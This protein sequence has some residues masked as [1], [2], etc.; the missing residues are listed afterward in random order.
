MP[1]RAKEPESAL[2]H[3]GDPGQ[4]EAY[5]YA[6]FRRIARRYDLLNRLLSGGRDVAWRRFA[7]ERTELTRGQKALD[8]A[9]GTGDLAFALARRVGPD[10]EVIGVDFVEEMLQLARTKQAGRP[11]GAVC[12]FMQGNALALPFEDGAFD[13]ATIGF[14]LRNVSDVEKCLTEMQRVVRPGGR[15]VCLELS[16]P[17]WPLF[18]N[19]Y[20]FY[21]HRLVPWIGRLIQG[22]DGPYRYLPDSVAR[23]PDQERLAEIMRSAGFEDVRYYNLTGGIAAV[24]V[25]V[26]P[27]PARAGDE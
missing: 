11:E 21:F 3:S 10:G 1:V 8:V 22:V 13:A 12:S 5:V 6:M 19:V 20:H 18:R 16:K 9:T 4:K 17:V 7:A 15:V 2:I 24:H 14:A 23:F 27:Q 25:G 26:V